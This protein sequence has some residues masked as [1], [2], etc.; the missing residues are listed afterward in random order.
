MILDGSAAN[1]DGPPNAAVAGAVQPNELGV[2]RCSTP[3]LSQWAGESCPCD[4]QGYA[5]VSKCQALGKLRLPRFSTLPGGRRSALVL[6]W[7]ASGGDC[8]ASGMRV[9]SSYRV[10]WSFPGGSVRR[11]KTP[12]AA[13]RRE[14]AEEIGLAASPLLAAGGACGTWDGRRNRVHFFELRLDQPPKLQLDNREIVAA[15][16]ISPGELRG[17]TLTGPVAYLGRTAP[18]GC[19]RLPQVTQR[20]PT[21]SNPTRPPSATGLRPFRVNSIT[22][23]ARKVTRRTLAHIPAVDFFGCGALSGRNVS[24]RRKRA[25]QSGHAGLTADATA[26]HFHRGAPAVAW[27]IA[28]MRSRAHPTRPG[29]PFRRRCERRTSRGRSTDPANDRACRHSFPPLG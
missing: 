14:L 21:E 23:G 25:N 18:S 16:L 11:G 7:P 29:S 4:W 24:S 5:E 15:R 28:T 17:M 6:R 26:H 13:A 1:D 22:L 8:C 10:E 3:R 19:H 12:E 27:P 9:R 20:I 2:F